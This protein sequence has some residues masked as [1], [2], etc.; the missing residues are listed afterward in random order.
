M[1][2]R[3]IKYLTLVLLFTATTQSCK[4]DDFTPQELINPNL[5]EVPDG[6]FESEKNANGFVDRI[7]L[8]N[9]A[10]MW[11][12]ITQDSLTS[13][14][15]ADTRSGDNASNPFWL[16]VAD[17]E[18]YTLGGETLSATHI[19]F[20]DNKAYVTYHKRGATHLGAIEV[21]DLSNPSS[22]KVI[23]NGYLSRS[24]VN[25]FTVAKDGQDVKVW[26]ALSDSNKGAVLGQLELSNNANFQGFS[27]VNLSNHIEGGITSSA[28]AVTK[29]DDYLYVSSGKTFGGAFCLDA[30]D[31]SVIGSV[32]FPN[33]KYVDVNG[34]EGSATKVV[35]L[36]TGDNSSIRIEDIGGFHF[37]EE[38]A[39]G[40]ILH[41]NVDL[42]SRG[43]SVLH[44]VDNNPKEVY[45]TMGMNG[46]SRVNIETGIETW[47]SPAD[48]I[49]TGNT[50]GITSDG[51]FIYAANGADGM[52][53]FTQPEVGESPERIFHWDLDE[54]VPASTN[55]IAAH[56]DWVFIA[57]GEG[58]VKILKRPQ[59]GDCMPIARFDNQG[60]PDNIIDEQ[61]VCNDPLSDFFQSF[62]SEGQHIPSAHPEFLSP[63]ATPH[64]LLTEDAELSLS[65]IRY[66]GGFNS[67]L[68]YYYYDSNNPPSSVDELI[69]LVTFPRATGT[70]HGGVLTEGNTVELVG[71]FKAGTVIGFF[72]HP[73]SFSN[74]NII[75][76]EQR[77]HSD[78][79]FNRENEQQTLMMYHAGCDA[80]VISFEEI[81]RPYG[82]QDFNDV[83]FQLKSY[84]NNA[85]D[86]SNFIQL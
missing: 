83:I 62:L 10:V 29:T 1:R 79:N 36:Q 73:N 26:M 20:L 51:E 61:I 45:V 69:K 6:F 43:K 33:G 8:E 63:T 24:D 32:E 5:S 21:V 14:Q 71:D 42:E 76:G 22:P 75:K 86:I 70:G 82:D 50:N 25:S 78:P 55:M 3:V 16:H 40:E 37:A 47:H 13:N 68:G 44:F 34:A 67:V 74:G 19:E 81:F 80:T 53:V 27:I 77:F 59:P 11:E 60:V 31:L 7:T 64:I 46:L 39:L 4:K 2:K 65:F 28:N 30:N 57:K 52:T 48:M 85:Y 12:K 84:P 49:T 58:G 23:F 15:N 54:E 35:S 72:L 38:F 18:P 66:G 41:Q 56:G 17:V 9:R